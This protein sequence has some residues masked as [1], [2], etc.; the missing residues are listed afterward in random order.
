MSEID[1]IT[2][3]I[4]LITFDFEILYKENPILALTLLQMLLLDEE[5]VKARIALI[6]AAGALAGSSSPP[7]GWYEA[8]MQFICQVGVFKAEENGRIEPAQIERLAAPYQ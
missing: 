2:F 8:E 5:A 7:P 6:K 3:D 4:D 1:L